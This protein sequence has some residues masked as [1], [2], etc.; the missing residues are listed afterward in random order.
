MAKPHTIL[1]PCYRPAFG[2]DFEHPGSA[3]ELDRRASAPASVPVAWI[4]GPAVALGMFVWLTFQLPAFDVDLE[5]T[6]V[7]VPAAG[8]ATPPSDRAA[9]LGGRASEPSA[10]KAGSPAPGSSC[11]YLVPRSARAQ[12]KMPIASGSG[13]PSPGSSPPP[14]N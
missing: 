14:A 9:R 2:F 8:P 1:G 11:G 5:D 7:A 3:P 4:L 13:V 10:G 12:G 6:L